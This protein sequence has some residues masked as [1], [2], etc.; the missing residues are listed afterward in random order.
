MRFWEIWL[1]IRI[2]IEAL[3]ER[4]IEGDAMTM[5]HRDEYLSA[6]QFPIYDD[7]LR[8]NF[9]V[10]MVLERWTVPTQWRDK[11]YVKWEGHRCFDS[12][13][14]T[15]QVNNREKKRQKE[16]IRETTARIRKGWLPGKRSKAIG[17]E[18]GRLSTLFAFLLVHIYAFRMEP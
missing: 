14:Q 4:E 12:R 3:M 13:T 9:S 8:K 7:R 6:H 18:K 1:I 10:V 11:R 2:Y 17:K 15:I 5:T 16:R